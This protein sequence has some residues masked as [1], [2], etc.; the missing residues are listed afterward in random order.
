MLSGKAEAGPSCSGTRQGLA[1]LLDDLPHHFARLINID[2]HPN[3]GASV[4]RCSW[5]E[6][7]APL[8]LQLHFPSII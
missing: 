1:A 2:T 7:P 4:L 5:D 3:G 8:H 6:V